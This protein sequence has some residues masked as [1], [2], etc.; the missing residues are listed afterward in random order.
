MRILDKNYVDEKVQEIYKCITGFDF[1]THKKQIAEIIEKVIS[2][3]VDRYQEVAFGK[4]DSKDV[5]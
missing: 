4:L 1:P 5:K 2:D 3:T